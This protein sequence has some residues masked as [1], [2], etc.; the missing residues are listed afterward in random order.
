MHEFRE[1]GATSSLEQ[2]STD[3]VS[4]FPCNW[5]V[6]TFEC[7]VNEG[8]SGGATVWKGTVFSGCSDTNEII[9]IHNRFSEETNI[10]AQCST[11]HITLT[12]HSVRVEN[13]IYISQL[14]VV[15]K[16]GHDNMPL[17]NV[18]CAH[19][20]G[21]TAID[22]DSITINTSYTC[23]LSEILNDSA[24]NHTTTLEG[25]AVVHW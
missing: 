16:P 3:K 25:I 12:G 18:T 1:V 24:I 21:T 5:R 7:I 8:G 17:K 4:A 11:G 14:E 13:N 23:I 19:D 22:I 6:I 15:I 2:I 10:S 20:D 9:L